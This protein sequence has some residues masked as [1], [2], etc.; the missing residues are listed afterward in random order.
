MCAS[1]RMRACAVDT[2]AVGEPGAVRVIA[3]V[4]SEKRVEDG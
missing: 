2:V 1:E 4:R 3:V